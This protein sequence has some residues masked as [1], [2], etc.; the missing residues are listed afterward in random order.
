MDVVDSSHP[1][2][3]SSRTPLESDNPE[4]WKP[5]K[6]PELALRQA[7]KNIAQ[8]D[9]YV[10]NFV[11]TSHKFINLICQWV[12]LLQISNSMYKCKLIKG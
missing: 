12:L 7:Q 5:Y 3:A 11:S 8:D 1:L 10:S 4:D 2:S 9:W 6:D